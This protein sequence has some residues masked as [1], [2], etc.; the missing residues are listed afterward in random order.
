MQICSQEVV[1]RDCPFEEDSVPQSAKFSATNRETLQRSL[2]LSRDNIPHIFRG[3]G[4]AP[5]GRGGMDIFPGSVDT[6]TGF[7]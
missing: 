7:R 3:N 1:F 5:P 6:R 4:D 2:S